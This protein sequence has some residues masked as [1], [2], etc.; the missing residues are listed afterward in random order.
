MIIAFF[1]CV[2]FEDQA[3]LIARGDLNGMRKWSITQKLERTIKWQHEL[4][5]L[6]VLV[7]QLAYV[8]IERKIPLII[9]NP[10][11]TQHYLQRYWCI[12]PKVI[13]YNRRESGDYYKKPT[14]YFFIGCEPKNNFIFEPLEWV[15]LKAI[16]HEHNKVKRSLI[17]P[18]YANKFLR[19][20]VL[21]KEINNEK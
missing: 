8:C 9:E 7:S 16:R 12:K 20:Y 3:I 17:H 10:Y 19:T 1:P 13:D 4:T 21:D 15:D 14:Q 18:Q 5:E 2:R 11:S 6:Y